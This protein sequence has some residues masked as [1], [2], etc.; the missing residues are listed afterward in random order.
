MPKIP[1]YRLHKASG[2]AVVWLGRDVY[3]GKHGSQ[4]SREKY[5]RLISEWLAS[6]RRPLI[7]GSENSDRPRSGNS[8]RFPERRKP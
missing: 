6:G 1:S 7:A 8:G 5:H 3:L 2:Q 4:E